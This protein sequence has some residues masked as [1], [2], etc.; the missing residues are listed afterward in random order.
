MKRVA[1]Y[2]RPL[3]LA[4]ILLTLIYMGVSRYKDYAFKSHLREQG[5]Y[6]VSYSYVLVWGRTDTYF[7]ICDPPEGADA[8]RSLIQNYVEADGFFESQRRRGEETVAELAEAAKE[9]RPF[10][11]MTFEFLEPSKAL[12]IGVFPYDIYRSE[13][14]I[15]PHTLGAAWV[16]FAG[17]SFEVEYYIRDG[18]SN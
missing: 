16:D 7:M 10:T 4:I 11:G 18:D 2:T 17:D 6:E 13:F 12:P 5:I 14:E 8:L 15:G 3:L 1:N 9:D